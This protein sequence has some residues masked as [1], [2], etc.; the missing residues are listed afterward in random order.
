MADKKKTEK[1]VRVTVKSEWAKLLAANERAPKAKRLCDEGLVKAMQKLFPAKKDKT[2]ITRC[3]MIRSIYNKG[4][5][6]FK[7]DGPAKVKS[8]R[9]D[10]N[11]DAI[12]GRVMK[13]R[14]AKPAP[15]AK[16]KAK[17]RVIVR[18]KPKAA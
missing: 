13:P 9:Y 11:G 6:M 7:A 15:A 17:V 5:G 2:T 3:N 16:P 10:S 14:A 1:P 18:A 8:V 4:T 12:T